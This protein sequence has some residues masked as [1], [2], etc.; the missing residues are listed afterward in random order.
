MMRNHIPFHVF[1]V[2]VLVLAFGFQVLSSAAEGPAG[3]DEPGNTTLD[4]Q[5]V[6]YYFH[7][8]FRCATCRK[9]ETYS[10]EAISDAFA[11]ELASGELIWKILNTDEKDHKHFV[12]DFELVTKSV[13]LVE[14]RDGQVVRFENL[15]DVWKLVGDKD[16]FIKYV[17]D[18]TREFLGQG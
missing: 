3:S 8:N 10:E 13:V 15:K 17:R 5:F 1:L 6:A 9:I 14:Y 4:P 11:D 16:D 2:V 18:S 12:K 7:G